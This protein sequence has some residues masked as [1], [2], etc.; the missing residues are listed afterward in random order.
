MDFHEIH[1]FY[2]FPSSTRP[3]HPPVPII[4]PSP[5]PTPPTPPSTR[6]PSHP[7]RTLSSSAVARPPWTS[8]APRP[9]RVNSR[10]AST[11]R[12]LR[13]RLAVCAATLVPSTPS[14]PIPPASRTPRAVRT[15]TSACITLTRA[16]LTFCTRSR[17]KGS[18]GCRDALGKETRYD[19][20]FYKW[21]RDQR[22]ML[23]SFFSASA[24][25]LALVWR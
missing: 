14:P 8:H 20:F 1:G 23:F 9:A 11:T 25:F 10:P 24:C 4:H 17:G 3:H 22:Q 2:G 15:A 19:F 18:T 21:D 13:T 5:R 7:K 12:S 6:P 16:T